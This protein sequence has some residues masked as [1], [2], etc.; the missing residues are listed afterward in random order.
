MTESDSGT[1]SDRQ[2]VLVA[3][4]YFGSSVVR[5]FVDSLVAQTTANWQLHLV[6]NS[7]DA[8]E[9]ERL[10]VS[11]GSDPRVHVHFADDNLGYFGGASWLLG[12]VAVRS[13]WLAVC[14]VDI[15]L[16]DTDFV[17]RL[18][19]L[20]TPAGII[21][22]RITGLP[23]SRELNPFMTERPSV[24][25]LKRRRRI[26]SKAITAQGY[27]VSAS[28]VARLRPRSGRFTQD[29]CE[30]YAPHGSFILFEG[31]SVETQGL[32][33]HPVF[34]FGE[35]ISVGEFAHKHSVTVLYEPALRVNHYE[36]Q[37]TGSWR[38]KRMLEAQRDATAY[39]WRL[40]ALDSE[41]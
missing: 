25:W 21:A 4:S 36:H 8:D 30:I 34:M 31:A 11:A 28:I 10:K 24:A 16:A 35:E 17:E 33:P 39:A 15:E 14:N 1:S 40:V 32:P 23:S 41:F 19:G 20:D 38:S 2:V 12:R 37:S 9:G 22:P 13:T 7:C 18:L 6:D 5:R 29:R 26:F 3:V 27:G